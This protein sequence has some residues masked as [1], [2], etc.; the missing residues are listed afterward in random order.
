MFGITRRRIIALLSIAA[1]FYA[2]IQYAQV[3]FCAA[4]FDDFIKTEVKFAPARDGMDTAHLATQIANASLEYGVDVD[5]R[6]IR[7][8]KIHN[9]QKNFD[10]LTVE[11]PYHAAVDLHL[12]KPQ[13]EFYTIATVKY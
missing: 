11:V 8:S 5:P 2:V 7:V 10:T 12:Y 4:E 6:Q 9:S 13:V 1:V 3:Y